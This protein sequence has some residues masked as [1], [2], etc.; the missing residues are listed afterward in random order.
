MRPLY[1]F[2]FG[3]C[4]P[5]AAGTISAFVEIQGDPPVPPACSQS[6]NNGGAGL[7]VSAS[8]SALGATVT[9]YQGGWHASVSAGVN[10]DWRQATSTSAILDYSD[11]VIIVGDSGS[12]FIRVDHF[13]TAWGIAFVDYYFAGYQ[14]SCFWNMYQCPTNPSTIQVPFG[15]PL[16]IFW[17]LEA[18]GG[19]SGFGD[20]YSSSASTYFTVSSITRA[21]GSPSTGHLQTVDSLPE[22]STILLTAIGWAAIV[23]FRLQVR[24]RPGRAW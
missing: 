20:W 23:A 3:V 14:F 5:A 7:V 18:Y 8:C 15:V 2:L 11:S 16:S 21:D 4:L 10:S 17:H 19:S 24:R 13:T 9:A 12:G 1:I 6:A 22:P